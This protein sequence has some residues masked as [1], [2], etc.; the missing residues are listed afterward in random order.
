MPKYYLAK[1]DPETYSITTFA[2]EKETNWDGV[3]NYQA[4]NFIKSWEIGDFVLIYNSQ[5]ENRIVGLAEVVG[6]PE[7][8][9]NDKRESWYAKLRLLKNLMR[10]KRLP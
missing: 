10:I 1:T 5:G 2:K 8:D 4:I 9:L 7:K 6:N 3:H